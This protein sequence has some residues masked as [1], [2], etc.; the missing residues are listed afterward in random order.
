MFVGLILL[1]MLVGETPDPDA[2]TVA[3]TAEQTAD[4][5]ATETSP[6]TPPDDTPTAATTPMSESTPEPTPEPTPAF[7][8]PIEFSGVGDDV[9]SFD[10]PDEAPGG[11]HFT[12]SGTSNFA[13][14]GYSQGGERTE[15]FVNTIGSYDGIRPIN[16]TAETTAEF[17]IA[18]D[19]A[20]AVSIFPLTAVR[21]AEASTEG[22]GD[23]LRNIAALDV[24]TA[25][26]THAGTS[27][28]AVLAWGSGRSLLINEIGSYSGRVRIPPETLVLEVVADG[29]WTI[30]FE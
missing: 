30:D 22:T 15:L 3:G 5:T 20:W 25:L 6:P 24:R 27:N 21:L 13:V 23:D 14:T 11:V 12:H 29:G 18:A 9:I 10:I 17:E 28:F 2:E 26:I 4:I 8:T 16:F 1:G 19:G 7:S